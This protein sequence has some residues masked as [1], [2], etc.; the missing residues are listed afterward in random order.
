MPLSTLSIASLAGRLKI[1]ILR[2]TTKSNWDEVVN[3]PI[4]F[5][6]C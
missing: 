4:L 2:A 6:D 3:C 5:I 1:V